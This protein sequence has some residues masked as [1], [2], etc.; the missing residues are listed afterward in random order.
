MGL[1]T[2][3]LNAGMASLM[4]L[5][6]LGAA[7]T[8]RAQTIDNVA[9]ASWRSGNDTKL[10]LSNRVSFDVQRTPLASITTFVPFP[11]GIQQVDLEPSYCTT[12]GGTV[13]PNSA[14]AG[15]GT[16]ASLTPVNTIRIGQTLVISIDAA[17]ANLDPNIKGN[18][19]LV[20]KALN[21]DTETL[22]A[23]ETEAD[24]GRFFASISTVASPPPFVNNDCRLSVSDGDAIEISAFVRGETV[25]FLLGSVNAEANPFAVVFDSLD[26]TLVDGAVVSI[27]NATTG[28]PA[29]VYG[30]D[31]VTPWPSTITTGTRV[32]DANGQTV[33]LAPGEYRF[34]ILASGNYRLV[35]KPPQPYVAPSAVSPDGLAGL[36]DGQG[37]PFDIFDGSYGRTFTVSDLL[38]I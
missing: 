5:L 28:Q 38:P 4:G 32:T 31:G 9:S 25:P 36:R 22:N 29:K 1:A 17:S 27:I 12:S 8:A 35:V 21:G 26:G 19:S 20:I 34:P 30:L 3:L 10:V 7:E 33:D 2:R 16:S 15:S 14:Q 6:S 11:G 23:V 13:I 37:Q 18:L 24:S